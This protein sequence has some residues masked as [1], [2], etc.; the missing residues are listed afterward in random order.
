MRILLADRRGTVRAEVTRGRISEVVWRLNKAGTANLFISRDDPAFREELLL[1]GARIYVEF[2]VNLP[3]WGGILDLP[4]VW[5][6]NTLQIRAWTIERLLRFVITSKTKAFYG[7]PVGGIFVEILRNVDDKAALGI[8][9][10]QVWRGGG[11][12]WPRYHLR[13]AMWVINNSLRKMETCDYRFSP[14]LTGGQVRFRAT[15]QQLLGDDKRNRVALVEGANVA[16]AL[17]T[18]Q[19]DVVNRV[20]VVGSGATWGERE[21]VYGVEE[22]SRRQ[23]GLREVA[24]TPQDVSQ[25]VTLDRYADTTIRENAYP[26]RLA[27][28]TVVNQAPAGFGDYDVGDIVTVQLPGYRFD[29]YDAP[30]RIVARGYD[31]RTGVCKVACDERFEYVPVLQ[32]EDE[33]EPGEGE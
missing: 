32:G 2:D 7:V 1:P 10:G 8:D 15:L 9:F 21:V 12:H 6:R 18:E 24:L 27:D 11:M 33:Y 28:L 16:D 4:R 19:G 22:T 29:G 13:D 31:P 17:L 14:I 25:T 20:V 26:H 30:M 5:T 3:A 23:Y